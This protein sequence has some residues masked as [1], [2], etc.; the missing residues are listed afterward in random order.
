MLADEHILLL[1]NLAESKKGE[2]SF[3][4]DLNFSRGFCYAKL[5]RYEEAISNFNTGLEIH[6][7]SPLALFQNADA[8]RHLGRFEDALQDLAIVIELRPKWFH[9]YALRVYVCSDLLQY[10][11]LFDDLNCVEQID[12]RL[13]SWANYNRGLFYYKQGKRHEALE[14]LTSVLHER[15]DLDLAYLF[16]G[17][18]YEELGDRDSAFA[19]YDMG[20]KV[21][22]QS[23]SCYF[24]RGNIFYERNQFDQAAKDFAAAFALLPNEH[25]I[26]FMKAIS[27]TESKN[28][29]E[30]MK[31][32]EQYLQ[33]EP[34]DSDAHASYA[35]SC[36]KCG[37]AEKMIAAFTRVIE[38]DPDCYEAYVNRGGVY[39]QLGK[40][41]LA[42]A[43]EEKA[44]TKIQNKKQQPMQFPRKPIISVDK[45]ILGDET[46]LQKLVPED[47][48]ND[49]G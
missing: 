27:L 6:P 46:T 5:E 11:K 7:E 2:S 39:D 13:V 19:D 12:A 37:D 49:Q 48:L 16:R 18:V 36:G 35:R 28:Y 40:T 29:K 30:A 4:G 31:C 43:D 8:K 38:L 22:P 32:F 15:N 10:E 1:I 26:L 44:K 17:R 23:A 24:M 41:E 42:K 34:K 3:M 47:I 14:A 9:A 20:L 25:E 21:N 33:L 45:A